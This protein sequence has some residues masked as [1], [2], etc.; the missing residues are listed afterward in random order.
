MP[1]NVMMMRKKRKVLMTLKRRPLYHKMQSQP[2]LDG[3][4]K[5]TRK[6]RINVQAMKCKILTSIW[7]RTRRRN[8]KSPHYLVPNL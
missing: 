6:M 7:K 3:S 8:L 1:T 5:M 4:S 2:I